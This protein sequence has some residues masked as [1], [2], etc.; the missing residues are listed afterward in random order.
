M[1]TEIGTICYGDLQAA[2][3][4]FMFFSFSAVAFEAKG[5]KNFFSLEKFQ[6]QL[7][8]LLKSFLI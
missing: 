5:F 6:W 8:T 3:Y 7:T 4:F 2:Q 1:C